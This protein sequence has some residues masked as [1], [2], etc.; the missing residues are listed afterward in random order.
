MRTRRAWIAVASLGRTTW[1]LSLLGLACSSDGEVKAAARKLDALVARRAPSQDVT[2]LF[3]TG[4]STVPSAE[5]V[6]LLAVWNKGSD[7]VLRAKLQSASTVMVYV[8]NPGPP[9]VCLVCLDRGNAV[10]D[11]SCF[12]N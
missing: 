1:A 9:I 4:V 3:G 10:Q 6:R 2:A 7:Q 12:N 5:A 8:P 11:Y